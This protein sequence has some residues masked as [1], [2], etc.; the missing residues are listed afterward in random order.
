MAVSSADK[1]IS[2]AGLCKSF[3]LP[4]QRETM[5]KTRVVNLARAA[6]SYEEL[7]VLK[8]VSFD[9]MRGEFFGIVGRNG[10]GKSTLLKLL[11]GIYFPTSGSLDVHG[12][13]T[14]FIELGVGFNPELTGRENVYLNGALFGFDRRDVNAMYDDIVAFAELEP[15]MD[16]K[17]K[18]YSSG[19]Q[20]RLAFSIAIRSDSEIL[21][22]DEVLAVGDAGFQQKCFAHFY[23]LKQTDRT[24]VFVSHDLD[25]VERY[26]DRAIYIDDGVVRA[27]GTT[28]DVIEEYMLDVFRRSSAEPHRGATGGAETGPLDAR[29]LDCAVSPREVDPSTPVT[30]TFTYELARALPHELRFALVKDGYAF[31]HMSTRGTVLDDRPGRRTAQFTMRTGG[32]LEGPHVVAAGVFHPNTGEQ[33]HLDTDLASFYVRG[34]DPTRRGMMR[35]EGDWNELPLPPSTPA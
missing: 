34:A 10:G 25:A 15:F 21:L 27:A 26:C 13:V 7:Q 17:L 14:P 31:A 8:D 2:V 29:M 11:A 23:E 6:H 20:V 19:M 22:I 32:L 28:H 5:M 1:S 30:L 33:Y 16:L 24:I 3:R 4:H 12:A 35:I 18:N 9:V